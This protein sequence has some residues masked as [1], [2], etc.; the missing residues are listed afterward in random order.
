MLKIGTQNDDKTALRRGDKPCFTGEILNKWKCNIQL[1]L[2]NAT[3]LA[4]VKATA[5]T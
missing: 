4:R 2:R 3:L 1:V 5:C